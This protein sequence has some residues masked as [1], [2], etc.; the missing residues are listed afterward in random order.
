ML[1]YNVL[2][3]AHFLAQRKSREAV[4]SQRYMKVVEIGVSAV[5]C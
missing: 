5:L 2:S 3:G 1:A 4:W